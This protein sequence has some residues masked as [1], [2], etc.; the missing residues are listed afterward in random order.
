MLSLGKSDHADWLS[1]RRCHTHKIKCS[2]E[3]PCTKCQNAGCADECTYVN[4]DRQI[5]VHERW[6]LVKY[7]QFSLLIS[8]SYLDQ[9]AAENERLREQLSQSP[10]ALSQSR[11]APQGMFVT[12]LVHNQPAAKYFQMN[13]PRMVT[14]LCRIP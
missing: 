13:M 10:A 12:W 11:L 2:G 9:L 8:S 5:K 6:S 1:C 3:Q 7:F 14:Q 4:R